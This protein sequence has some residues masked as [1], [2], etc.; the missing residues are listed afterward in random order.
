[1]I[2]SL[3]NNT[4]VQIDCFRLENDMFVLTHLEDVIKKGLKGAI[5]SFS[6]KI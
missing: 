4:S 5:R 3:F 2:S 1:M 6:A